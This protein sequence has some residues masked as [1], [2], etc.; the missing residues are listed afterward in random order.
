MRITRPSIVVLWL[1][2]VRK[3]TT[4]SISLASLSHPSA[5]LTSENASSLGTPLNPSLRPPVR[6]HPD[7][8][9]KPTRM[10]AGLVT[11]L[12]LTTIARSWVVE[13]PYALPASSRLRDDTFPEE[14]QFHLTEPGE[15]FTSQTAAWAC[16]DGL[17]SLFDGARELD[18]IWRVPV[19]DMFLGQ[20]TAVL[21]QLLLKSDVLPPEVENSNT[22]IQE[23][24]GDVA[25]SIGTSRRLKSRRPLNAIVTGEDAFR[26]QAPYLDSNGELEIH[27]RFTGKELGP[28]SI[29]FLL[30]EVLRLLPWQ[31]YANN[32][33]S[34][35][36]HGGEVISSDPTTT[37][38][39]LD[40]TILKVD[41][42]GKEVRWLE[43]VEVLR[44]VLVEPTIR[45]QWDSFTADAGF[46]GE[47]P[48]LRVKVFKS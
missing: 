47:Q 29:L 17:G 33:I 7:Q 27:Q 45:N 22:S 16:L 24:G 25:A 21:G 3:S 48:F 11:H 19:Y 9:V 2:Q 5:Q 35:Q 30:Y 38:V 41:S 26:I 10:Q 28:R 23:H 44:Q 6:I 20:D 12:L 8:D 15:N 36:F 1:L 32:S 4:Q 40:M 46:P 42:E 31:R 37:G 13:R 18:Q 39:Q 14:T 43:M 34:N